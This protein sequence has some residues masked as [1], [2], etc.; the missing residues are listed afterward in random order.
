M[1]LASLFRQA[2]GL[3]DDAAEKDRL[4]DFNKLKLQE[5]FARAREKA[6]FSVQFAVLAL[7]SLTVINGGAIIALFTLIG[8][9]GSAGAAKFLTHSALL[10]PAFGSFALGLFLALLASFFAYLAQF[11]QADAE[12]SSPYNSYIDITGAGD[13]KLDYEGNLKRFRI[14]RR[15]AFIVSAASLGMFLLGGGFALS[16]ALPAP[17]ATTKPAQQSQATSEKR[18]AEKSP[19]STPAAGQSQPQALP[20]R[21]PSTPAVTQSPASGG[22]GR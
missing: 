21:T 3:S 4:L 8:A 20:A 18:G 19:P 16:A 11:H 9:T 15:L 14:F 2:I 12:Y 17:A 6:G 22:T 7:R 5:E 10:W 1:S 13:Q